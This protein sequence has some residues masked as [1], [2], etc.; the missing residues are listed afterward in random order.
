MANTYT[1]SKTDGNEKITIQAG[2]YSGNVTGS[3]TQDTDLL[4]YGRGAFNWGQGIEQNL[5]RLTENWACTAEN[6]SADANSQFPKSSDPRSNIGIS[7]PMIGQTWFNKSNGR[8]YVNIT[9]ENVAGSW[10]IDGEGRYLKSTGGTVT[11]DVRISVDSPDL[12]LHSTTANFGHNSHIVFEGT[13]ENNVRS[14]TGL[15]FSDN[16]TGSLR[17]QNYVRDADG[18]TINSEI[19][20]HNGYVQVPNYITTDVTTENIEN[21]SDDN[22]VVNR[23]YVSDKFISNEGT[24]TINGRLIVTSPTDGASPYIRI[25]AP[26][27]TGEVDGKQ[28][29]LYFA[30][31]QRDKMAIKI[32]QGSFTPSNGAYPDGGNIADGTDTWAFE[33]YDGGGT[34]R[35]AIYFLDS[36]IET[37]NNNGKIRSPATIMSGASEDHERTLLTL[38]SAKDYFQSNAGAI[39]QA[40]EKISI[41]KPN[42]N[43][44]FAQFT[45]DSSVRMNL[46]TSSQNNSGVSQ[47]EVSFSG[48]DDDDIDS[49]NNPVNKKLVSL[50]LNT[51]STPDNVTDPKNAFYIRK[52]GGTTNAILN[53]IALTNDETIFRKDI[54]LTSGNVKVDGELELLAK[55]PNIEFGGGSQTTLTLA[56]GLELKTAFGSDITVTRT[57]CKVQ[58]FDGTDFTI[59]TDRITANKPFRNTDIPSS[60]ESVPDNADFA[61]NSSL[62]ART[63][64]R[65]QF[66]DLPVKVM[67][68]TVGNTPEANKWYDGD[69]NNML[70]IT[71]NP[72][73]NATESDEDDTKQILVGTLKKNVLT[74]PF[75]VVEVS[76]PYI[77]TTQNGGDFWISRE[78][79]VDVQSNIRADQDN[80]I[81]TKIPIGYITFH[82]SG[83]NVGYFQGTFTIPLQ[84][85]DGDNNVYGHYVSWRWSKE[86]FGGAE[87]PGT[88]FKSLVVGRGR[89]SHRLA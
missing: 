73:M 57:E 86:T 63:F 6:P 4:L 28:A 76:T 37:H 67:K 19:I 62:I 15:I 9:G 70:N 69:P 56:S 88:V 74:Q 41:I 27:I 53:E 87:S 49:D 32:L 23:Q 22:V 26:N 43:G 78:V 71:D 81:W 14:R 25:Q 40:N 11:N 75:V 47:T 45:G 42:D 50:L 89:W 21:Y 35:Q 46:K 82:S 20:L 80:D 18:D 33:K 8:L 85:P 51:D 65:L 64:K 34:N 2:S 5:V 30:D 72:S 29:A 39:T 44:T 52:F 58:L 68:P 54:K 7:K 1:I 16:S 31:A 48:V 38:G 77:L 36:H 10:K 55:T 83:Q 13:D 17:L 60:N 3:A 79:F 84:E 61:T 59:G 12:Y 24:N 66:E